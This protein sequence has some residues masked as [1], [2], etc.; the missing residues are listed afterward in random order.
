MLGEIYEKID[1]IQRH[2]EDLD[3]EEKL[4][5]QE[6]FA[7]FIG[8]GVNIGAELEID[9]LDR[10]HVKKDHLKETAAELLEFVRMFTTIGGQALLSQADNG[11]EILEEARRLCRKA[12]GEE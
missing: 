2:A 6:N 1:K 7:A 4:I 11:K 8:I 5:K 10:F 3:N 12:R 9:K